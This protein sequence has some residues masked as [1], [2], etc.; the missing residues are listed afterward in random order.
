MRE[1]QQRAQEHGRVVY[2]IVFPERV[3]FQ[4][5]TSAVNAV[6]GNLTNGKWSLS[7]Q[8]MVQELLHTEHGIRHRLRVPAGE[9]ARQIYNQLEGHFPGVH[10]QEVDEPGYPRWVYGKEY[11]TTDPYGCLDIGDGVAYTTTLLNSAQ[12]LGPREATVL[13][14]VYTLAAHERPPAKEPPPAV[15]VKVPVVG[16]LVSFKSAD[17]RD[18]NEK[19]REPN[20][21]AV[22]RI[23]AAAENANR[24]RALVGGVES[25]M[26]SAD[27]QAR[28][29]SLVA[30]GDVLQ[31]VH[32]AAAPRWKFPAQLTLS[33]VAA[34][35]GVR[36][37][38]ADIAGIQRPPTRHMRADPTIP[39]EG[40]LL[41]HSTV[42]SNPRRVAM[43]PADS[44]MHV[45]TLGKNG[46]G[47]SSVFKN[48][49]SQV[50]RSP[51]V[52]PEGKPQQQGFM[53]LDPHGD[54]A[55]A[56]LSDIP[57]ERIEDVVYIDPTSPNPVG[58]NLM[59]GASPSLTTSYLMGVV[60]SMFGVGPLTGHVLRNTIT[61]VAMH[62]GMTLHEVALALDD[63]DFRDELTRGLRDEQL[64]RYWTRFENLSRAEQAQTTEPVMRRL[65]VFLTPE[66]RGIFGQ[67]G[68]LDMWDAINDGKIIVL[69]L[70]QGKIGEANANLLG[71][72]AVAKLWAAAKE[73]ATIPEEWRRPFYLFVDE[74]PRFMK[75]PT[76]LG[77]MLAEARKFR[78][79]C[80]LASQ[81]I[82]Q[83]REI[84]N[85]VIVNCRTKIV[86]ESSSG[87]GALIGREIGVDSE[88]IR[89]LPQHTAIL[90]VPHAPPATIKT[91]RP[92]R[93]L[94]AAGEVIRASQANYGKPLEDVELEIASRRSAR[95][96]P[97]RMRPKFGKEE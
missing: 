57:E 24:A 42:P 19:L 90:S 21:I 97:K 93:P 45:L 35:M 41:G 91:I 69:N 3:T 1:R 49:A 67:S 22:I 79:S 89:R 23:A 38:Q 48:A 87:D 11:G 15:K 36:V 27:G 29:R 25:A 74:A 86:F 64:N 52:D 62:G 78:L 66:F 92:S 75:L 88:D 17:K 30:H 82:G 4:Q 61:T 95:I 59:N 2:E 16:N 51:W 94:R 76:S 37:N 70:A 72:M 9:R 68:G 54:L 44:M 6:R 13:Q 7:P 32:Q 39:K 80:W 28:F 12:N 81:S 65:G 47:K 10:V 71:A 83:V 40:I 85:D 55:E 53:V 8:T 60:E 20:F 18:R 77:E 5:V 46:T 96:G 31:R 56:M 84:A 63:P 58:L 34:L 43:R 50:I 14:V 26:R 73:R 33:E